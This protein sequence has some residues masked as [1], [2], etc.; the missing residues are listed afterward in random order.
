MTGGA[1]RQPHLKNPPNYLSRHLIP[2]LY[3]K[4]AHNNQQTI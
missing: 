3:I 4:I 1:V 2:N